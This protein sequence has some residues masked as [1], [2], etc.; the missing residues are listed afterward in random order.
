MK[1]TDKKFN[2]RRL[3]TSLTLVVLAIF[4][5]SAFSLPSLV[6]AQESTLPENTC[7]T[8]DFLCGAG[9]VVGWIIYIINQ[10]MLTLVGWLAGA[11][12]WLI[13]KGTEVVSLPAVKSG[14]GISL[15]IVNL[16]F[17]AA[18]I[19]IAFQMILGYNEGEAKKRLGHV[20]LAA[21]LINF[22]LLIAGFLLDISNVLTVFFTDSISADN[23]RNSLNPNLFQLRGTSSMAFGSAETTG[24]WGMVLGQ[25]SGLLFTA[26]ILVIMVAVFATA[27]VRN[28]IVSFLLI[29]MPLTWGFWVFPGLSE[30][31]SR[32][33]KE[34]MKWGVT[35]LPVMTFFIYLGI[36]TAN[37]MRSASNT[38]GL[39]DGIM[40]MLMVGGLFVA[41]LKA[42]QEAGGITASAATSVARKAAGYA[43]KPFYNRFTK[44]AFQKGGG[45]I[46]KGITNMASSNNFAAKWAGKALTVAG[47]AGGA[48]TYAH[49][50]E[51]DLEDQSKKQYGA[52][53][54][55]QLSGLALTTKTDSEKAK[56]LMALAKMKDGV[57]E[58]AKTPAGVTA[59]A[60]LSTAYKK[61]THKDAGDLEGV[62]DVINENPALAPELANKSMEE[63]VSKMSPSK[64]AEIKPDSIDRTINPTASLLVKKIS[65]SSSQIKAV[66]NG[67]PQLRIKFESELTSQIDAELSPTEKAR[68]DTI[69][70]ELIQIAKEINDARAVH[71]N[72]ALTML[73]RERETRRL[74]LETTEAGKSDSFKKLSAARKTLL[75]MADG[76]STNIF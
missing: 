20:I 34:F 60:G 50:R 43:S 70:T 67:P 4:I 25:L 38:S 65:E 14:F 23:I 15:S 68:T 57:K 53:T 51:K 3:L 12:V 39:F 33:W 74:E 41:G 8:F 69:N 30:Y 55:E 29:V 24:F 72:A 56:V 40:N 49:G 46:S 11:T 35:V 44:S 9:Y 36:M 16:I 31:H 27:L 26:I 61:E 1:L 66:V 52:M 62:K 18:L 54:K 73:Q 10:A 47:V 7:S 21:L 32:W 45:A 37:G 48:A 13:S 2:W 19:T 63:W 28:I 75:Q 59:L 6:R 58:L 22:S 17:V 64:V 42:G 71:D 5:V 76:T